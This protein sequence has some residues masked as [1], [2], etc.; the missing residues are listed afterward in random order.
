MGCIIS[1]DFLLIS[2]VIDDSDKI[3]IKTDDRLIPAPRGYVQG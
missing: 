3:G 2:A 1:S